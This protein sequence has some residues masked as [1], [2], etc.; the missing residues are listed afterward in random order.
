MKVR[1]Q[2]APNDSSEELQLLDYR[3]TQYNLFTLLATAY[4]FQF[5]GQEVLILYR[6]MEKGTALAYIK[7]D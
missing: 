4:A 2:F 5:A 6:N 7:L 1:R 3:T